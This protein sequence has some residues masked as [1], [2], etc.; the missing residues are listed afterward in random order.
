MTDDPARP[1]TAALRRA[2]EAAGDG[3]LPADRDWAALLTMVAVESHHRM[4]QF[5]GPLPF[6]EPRPISGYYRERRVA[7]DALALAA[8]AWEEREALRGSGF[9]VGH[10]PTDACL[11]DDLSAAIREPAGEGD[12]T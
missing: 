6:G 7:A 11:S 12:P 10:I 2:L 9:V 3:P 8:R 4:L 1:A 5:C